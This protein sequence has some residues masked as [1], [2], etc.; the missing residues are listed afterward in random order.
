MTTTQLPTLKLE[1]TFNATP[2]RLWSY[3]RGTY[4]VVD[5]P[6]HL[7]WAWHFDVYLK[8]HEKPYDVPIEITLTPTPMG[9]TQ[10]VFKQGPLAA[11]EHTLGSRGGVLQNLEFLANALERA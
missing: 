2:E 4:R 10:V 8:P 5:E 3:Y 7:A 6:R 1:R 9:R 11:R